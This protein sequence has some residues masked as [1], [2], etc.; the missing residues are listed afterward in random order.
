[1]LELYP[2]P[3]FVTLLK[4][5]VI[6]ERPQDI[7]LT[8]IHDSSTPSDINQFLIYHTIRITILDNESTLNTKLDND[9]I[10]Y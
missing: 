5:G 2:V 10:P 7:I 8:L 3:V 9:N 1:M 4:D 6:G